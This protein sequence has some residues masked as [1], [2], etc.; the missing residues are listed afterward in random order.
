MPKK[1]GKA[2]VLAFARALDSSDAW[3]TQAARTDPSRETPVR[4]REKSVRGTISNRLEDA[5]ANDPAKLNAQ[6]EKPNLQTVD[7]ATLDEDKDTLIARFTLKTLPFSGKPWICNDLDHQEKICAAIDAY[8]AEN[9]LDELSRRYAENIANAR[10]LWRN[11]IGADRIAVT[12][13]N[14]DETVTIDDAKSCRLNTSFDTSSDEVAKIAD[15]L[16]EGLERKQFTLLKVEARAFMGAGQE[17]FPSQEL[18]L[19]KGASKKSKVLYSINDKAGIHSQKIGN[20]L[21]TIDTW[22]DEAEFPIAVEPYG[23]VTTLGHCF[24][25]SRKSFYTLFDNWVLKDKKPTLEE[26]HYVAAVLIR[27]GVFSEPQNNKK[28]E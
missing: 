13:T 7:V 6:I 22:Y 15:W 28:K 1:P 26:Q 5:T 23:A 25:P 3:F 4:L 11:R 9:G 27:G 10:W 17:V 20:A 8:I 2:S 19:D 14:G 12:V 16:R 18:I 21:R 24:R